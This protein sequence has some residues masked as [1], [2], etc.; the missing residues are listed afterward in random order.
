MSLPLFDQVFSQGESKRPVRRSA[1]LSQRVSPAR[2]SDP[3]TCEE[4]ASKAPEIRGKQRVLVYEYLVSR[5]A[6]GA[7]DF[8]IGQALSILRTSAGKRRKELMDLGYVID[9]GDK[10]A[11][12]T[13]ARGIVWRVK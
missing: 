3:P 12:D 9:S 11:T 2:R 13:G 4:A 6:R 5:G 7:T 1:I 10:R 8:E